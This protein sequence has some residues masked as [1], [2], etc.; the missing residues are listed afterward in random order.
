MSETTPSRSFPDAGRIS[1]L[2]ATIL[3]AYVLARIIN[4]PGLEL[5]SQLPGFYFQ[6]DINIGTVVA[7]LVAWLTASGAVWLLH[8]HPALKDKNLVQH[9]LLPSLTALVIGLPLSQ[10][11][12]NAAW[13]VA[14]A[15]GGAILMIVLVAE[16]ISVN[17]EDVFHAP[18]TVVLTAIS[19][20]LFLAL[21]VTLRVASLRLY[22]LMPAVFFAIGLVSLRTLN[23]RLHGRWALYQSLVIALF[24]TQLAAALHYL[25]LQ[26][27]IF[28]LILLGPAYALTSLIYNIMSGMRFSQAITEPILVLLIVWG[29]TLWIR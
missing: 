17:P 19:F 23:L 20:A 26:P 15:I 6:I 24:I 4:L 25:P 13:W 1:I 11:P 21:V 10:M 9:W 12:L 5:A 28:G 3:L 2:S 16:Y 18:A 29:F 14:L 8:D 27:V 22:L 7:V